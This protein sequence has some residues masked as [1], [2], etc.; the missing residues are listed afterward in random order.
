VSAGPRGQRARVI[1]RG[2][3]FLGERQAMPHVPERFLVHFLV[4][5]DGEDRLGPIEQGMPGRLDVG[6]LQRVDDEPV[7]LCGK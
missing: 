6:M 1:V 2:R 5:E 4:L 3:G 7:R